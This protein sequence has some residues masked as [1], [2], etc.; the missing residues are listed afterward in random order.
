MS[1]ESDFLSLSLNDSLKAGVRLLGFDRMTEIQAKSLPL[2]LQ[3]EDVIAQAKTG[4]GKTAAFGLGVLQRLDIV[5]FEVQAM[6]LCPTRELAQQV[7]DDIRALGKTTP[8]LKVTTLTGG[9]PLAAQVTSLNNGVHVVV[10][11][12]G[13]VLDHCERNTVSFD[14][15]TCLVLD[16]ADR[17]LDMG[18]QDDIERILAH[19]PQQRQTLLFSAT[20]PDGIHAIAQQYMQS[21]QHIEVDAS[22]DTP[23]GITQRFVR[24]A[25][26][27]ERLEAL[28]RTLMAEHDGSSL[29]FCNTKVQADEVADALSD[30]GFSA[31]ALHGDYEQRERDQVMVQFANHSVSVLVATDVA[32]RGLDV[33]EMGLVV[34]Y[35]LAHDLD[36]H[37]HRIGRTGRAGAQGLAVTLLSEREGHKLECMLDERDGHDALVIQFDGLPDKSVLSRAIRQAPNVTLR[38][39]G[40]K[41]D[42][43]RPGDILG[44]LTGEGGLDGAD[45]GKIKIQA[46]RSFVAVHRSAAKRAIQKLERDK[47][48]GRRFRVRV[49]S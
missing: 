38:I 23:Q 30:L 4:S 42:K 22:H 24:V 36:V 12:P 17:M 44:A 49:L 6:A 10:G 45:V 8:N 5:R 26:D 46:K 40:G 34:N 29:V 13:R 25:H 39:E 11:T 2:V 35:Q 1:P 48:K 3:G 43:L 28:T 47:L 7:A 27:G 32:A 19:L 15:L 21:P 18:F 16:E 14:A 37:T 9:V 20:F 31:Q 41:K 33:D